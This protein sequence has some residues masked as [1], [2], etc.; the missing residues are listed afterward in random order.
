MK[1]HHL[2]HQAHRVSKLVAIK[3][4]ERTY[5]IKKMM[6]YNDKMRVERERDLSTDLLAV[7][8]VEEPKIFKIR[9]AIILKTYLAICSVIYNLKKGICL[10]CFR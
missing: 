9:A 10:F 2:R 4:P 5:K 6:M 8:G 1:E 7:A 3:V